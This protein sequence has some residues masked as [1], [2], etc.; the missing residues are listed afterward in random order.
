[1]GFKTPLQKQLQ[2]LV[3]KNEVVTV[4]EHVRKVATKVDTFEE[5]V[6]ATKK[7]LEKT[8]S[9]VERVEGAIQEH[10]KKIQQM[11][12]EMAKINAGVGLADRLTRRRKTMEHDTGGGERGQWTPSFISLNGW[13]DW[14][15]KM[16]TM[17]DSM[18]ARKW[19][20]SIITNLPT[21]R[22]SCHR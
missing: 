22:K 12:E 13:V 21:H 19:V 10:A 5:K 3:V 18:T 20:D 15:R 9:R 16:E 11:K 8:N 14:D 17:M 1:M 4:G 6:S 7:L 2:L